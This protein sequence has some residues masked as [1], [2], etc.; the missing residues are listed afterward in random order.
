MGSHLL[1]LSIPDPRTHTLPY[2]LVH[3]RLLSLQALYQAGE[4][5]WGTDES[6][7]VYTDL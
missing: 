4:A 7:S 5:R 6:R 1:L 3:V 2:S